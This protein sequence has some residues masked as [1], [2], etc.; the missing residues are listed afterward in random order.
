MEAILTQ[1]RHDYKVCRKHILKNEGKKKCSYNY[2]RT[3]EE[4]ADDILRY[5]K[6]FAGKRFSVSHFIDSIDR[7]IKNDEE[8][9]ASKKKQNIRKYKIKRVV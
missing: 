3:Y 2:S 4:E 8:L 9:K 6:K 5:L 7:E 1:A